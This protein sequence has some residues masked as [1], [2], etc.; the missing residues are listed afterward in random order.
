M[1]SP[2]TKID[3]GRTGKLLAEIMDDLR[4]EN[5]SLRRSNEVLVNALEEIV[6]SGFYAGLNHTPRQIARRA[7]IESRNR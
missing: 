2:Q 4:H 3:T 7:I 6:N 5:E 1:E